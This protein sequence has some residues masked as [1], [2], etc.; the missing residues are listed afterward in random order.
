M[1]DAFAI[2]PLA[3]NVTA[4]F[5]ALSYNGTL[6]LSVDADAAAWPDI[7]NLIRGMS[8][9]WGSLSLVLAA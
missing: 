9:E 5:A 2:T 7:D 8:E 3:G 6:D 4:S 1:R